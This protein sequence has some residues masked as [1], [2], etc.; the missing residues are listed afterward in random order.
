MSA[1]KPLSGRR[2]TDLVTLIS[3][4]P[5]EEQ[6]LVGRLF[7]VIPTTGH[8]VVPE[9]MVGWVEKTFGSL[10]AVQEQ[11]IVRV[12]NRVT[13]EGALFNELRASRPIDA[14]GTAPDLRREIESTTGDPFC[15]PEEWTPADV[16]GRVRG[17]YSTTASNVAKYDGFHGL[18]VFDDHDPLDFTPEK[19]DDYV[20][21]ALGWL[22]KARKTDPEA[23][24]PFLMWNCLW[25]AGSSVVHGHM[26]MT[27]TSG[28]HYPKVE[29]LRR[30]ALGYRSTHG[31]DYFS[32]LYRT[33]ESL[34]LTLSGSSETR[35]F[36][37][38]TPIKEKEVM[39]LGPDL[40]EPLRRLLTGVLSRYT[41]D[42]G[43]S[44][45]NVA[46]YMPPVSPTG[47]DWSRFPVVIRMVDRGDPA[48][49]TSDIGAMEL[50]AAPVVSSDPF[51]V[52]HLLKG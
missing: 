37:S 28:T 2:V 6:E 19:V 46:F 20:S 29:H 44:S 24:Y 3:D 38:L 7:E 21:V 11:R 18:V 43:V 30:A 50:Y 42:L 14:H 22:E 49:R 23:K 10:H 51:R 27:A 33:H 15:S 47:E 35:G 13:L 34:G 1:G 26:Q 39:L 12:T 41:K 45:F 32:D 4:L 9:E 16:F 25:R 31:S 5:L 40:G 8:L 17:S 36:V 48:N 52:A